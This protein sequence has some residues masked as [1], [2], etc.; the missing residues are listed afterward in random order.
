MEVRMKK[1][2]LTLAIIL[3]IALV[4]PG[5]VSAALPGSGWWSALAAQNIGQDGGAMQMVAY[6][7]TNTY[8]SANEI[9]DYGQALV[10]DPGKTSGTGNIIGFSPSLPDA[11]EG[12]VV[13]SSDTPLAAVSE[14]A[15]YSNGTVGGNGTASAMYQGSSSSMTSNE[16][17]VTTVKHN[18]SDQTTTIYVQAAGS[19]AN[20]TVTYNMNNGSTYTQNQNITANRMFVFDP[21]NASGG[22][23]PSTNCGYDPN[24]SPCFGAAV[25]TS[26]TGPIAASY[27]EHP[28]QGSPAYL[29][30][31]ARAQSSADESTKL[32]GPS[33]K[34]TYTTGSGTGITGDAIMNVG[35]GRAKVKIT[36][37]V[38]KLGKNAPGSVSVGD[39]FEDFEY[40]DPNKS[41]VFSKWDN[42]L[43][44]MPEGTYAAAVFESIAEPSTGIT[45]QPLLGASNDAKTMSPIP[46]GKGKTVYQLF[47]TEALTDAIAVP[48]LTEF[49]DG[50]T[51]GLTVQ[52]VGGTS[53]KIHFEFYEHGSSNMYHFWTKDPLQPEEAINS[54]GVSQNYGGYFENGGAFSWSDL[55]G[56]QFSVIV[57]SEGGQP[58]NC[59]V[60]ENSPDSDVD[61][62][63]YEG[64][65]FTK[66]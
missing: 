48:I 4:V 51:G 14:I 25:I 55:D 33:I 31:A 21:A 43:G 37:T 22:G 28:H 26:S 11:F 34:H 13:I 32:Y 15:N 12:S 54:W 41:V 46:G 24:A 44:G 19:D 47:A 62:R 17:M 39:K 18:Y 59:V 42:N 63:N 8:S 58:I 1:I 29:A 61:I 64:F 60:F 36:L 45:P 35:T 49:E 9:F 40:I 53:S 30:L 66:P 50:L 57:Y 27:V 7:A 10:Y 2:I 20:V 23:V 16:L 56:K 6:D 65:S 3:L 38:T 5:V 52:N